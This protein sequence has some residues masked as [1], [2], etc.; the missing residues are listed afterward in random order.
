VIDLNALVEHVKTGWLPLPR[1]IV[2]P[3]RPIF[4]W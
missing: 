3:E 4:L 2:P 1:S